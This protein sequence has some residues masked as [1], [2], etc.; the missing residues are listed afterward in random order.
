MDLIAVV[1]ALSV[2]LN[3]YLV[4]RGI[5]LIG[6]AQKIAQERDYLTQKNYMLFEKLLSDLRS[7]DLRGAFE[8]DDEVGF[9]FIQIKEMVEFYRKLIDDE[10]TNDG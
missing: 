9:T 8:S 7:I 3:L 10:Q 4:Y 6:V 2:S 1:I 5:Y